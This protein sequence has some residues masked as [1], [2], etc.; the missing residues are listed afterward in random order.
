M[1]T[2][3]HY[4]LDKIVF[5]SPQFLQPP[6]KGEE[7]QIKK[8]VL[9]A[10]YSHG[11]LTAIDDYGFGYKPRIK[12]EFIQDFWEPA[13]DT[14]LAQI[15]TS[16]LCE[17]DKL[18][19]VYSY[20]QNGKDSYFSHYNKVIL[21]DEAWK[22]EVSVLLDSLKNTGC[23]LSETRILLNVGYPR[24]FPTDTKAVYASDY[25]A[26][27]QSDAFNSHFLR[28]RHY[29]VAARSASGSISGR[30]AGTSSIA[31]KEARKVMARNSENPA[32]LEERLAL[33]DAENLLLKGRAKKAL[34]AMA[35][36]GDDIN[37][38]NE[39]YACYVKDV[40]YRKT[41]RPELA[42]DCYDQLQE[43]KDNE[44]FV[45]LYNANQ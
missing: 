37:A 20:F 5:A 42:A 24:N 13:C 15:E 12:E 30:L 38:S 36:L 21:A 9:V 28:A 25:V 11:D 39:A 35:A 33:M 34:K 27:E 43:A 29:Q 32:S 6:A 31:I 45:A 44:K 17:S 22:N 16:S 1:Y 19:R 18:V 2:E 10:T 14:V 40:A 4:C 3:E 26:R 8:L 41:N 7:F 23:V